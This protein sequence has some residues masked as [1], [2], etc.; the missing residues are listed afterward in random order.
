M[1][2]SAGHELSKGFLAQRRIIHAL[3][4]RDVMMRYGRDNV[5][6]VWAILEPMILT[7]GVMVIWSFIKPP[8]EHGLRVAEFVMTGYMPL[9]LWRHMS[10]TTVTLFRRSAALLY[11]RRITLLDI[12]FAKLALEFV[13][14]STALLFVLGFAIT[15]GVVEPIQD[16]EPVLVGWFMMAWLASGVG[17]II[18]VLTEIAEVAERFIQPIQY[19]LLPVSGVFYLVDWLPYSYQRVALLNPLVHCYEAFRTGFFGHEIATYYDMWYV[20]AWA[21]GF[22]FVGMI[23]MRVAR[24]R[25][26]LS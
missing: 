24:S 3:M 5:G 4:V 16:V 14:T 25:V 13:A 19:L 7:A 17:M 10:S 18:A 9:T 11:H 12:V 15:V 1:A 2:R 23:L 20:A 26:Q 22:T 8:T 6:F 21:F